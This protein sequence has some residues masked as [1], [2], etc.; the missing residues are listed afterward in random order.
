MLWDVHQDENSFPN[1]G[2]LS[3][4]IVPG[5]AATM[6]HSKMKAGFPVHFW[7]CPV[8]LEAGKGEWVTLEAVS[9]PQ[10]S[11]GPLRWS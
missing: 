4:R 5:Y 11:C 6:Q 2:P 7:D 9:S 1:C 10:S 8:V 3:V